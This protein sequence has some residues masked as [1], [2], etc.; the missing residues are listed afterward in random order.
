MTHGR[1]AS[2][3][4]W[5]SPGEYGCVLS[6]I[7]MQSARHVALATPSWSESEHLC[8]RAL[9][10]L[11]SRLRTRSRSESVRERASKIKSAARKREASDIEDSQSGGIPSRKLREGNI[12]QPSSLCP[13]PLNSAG[14]LL[15]HSPKPAHPLQPAHPSP[16]ASL[17]HRPPIPAATGHH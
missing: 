15:A 8:E 2:A 1:S 16:A 3:S 13:P 5:R 12:R 14:I 7:S 9:I 4:S 11:T 17:P 6:G 10:G